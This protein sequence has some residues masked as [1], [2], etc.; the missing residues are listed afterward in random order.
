V[1]NRFLSVVETSDRL[2]CQGATAGRVALSVRRAPRV[3]GNERAGTRKK[4][5]C[6]LPAR[7]NKARNLYPQ[8]AAVPISNK[9]HPTRTSRSIA[10][11]LNPRQCNTAVKA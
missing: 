6:R 7:N 8:I 2:L 10:V 9:T 4:L 5:P 3:S 1:E 11:L